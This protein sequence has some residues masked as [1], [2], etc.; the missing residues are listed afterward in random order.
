MRASTGDGARDPHPLQV[1]CADLVFRLDQPLPPGSF[2]FPALRGALG[3]ALSLCPAEIAREF[4]A[5][6]FHPPA[7]RIASWRMEPGEHCGMDPSLL[8]ARFYCFGPTAAED[9]ATI[10]AALNCPTLDLESASFRVRARFCAASE[11]CLWSLPSEPTAAPTLAPALEVIMRTPV[12]I[13]SKGTPIRT[14]SFRLRSLIDS[15][16]LRFRHLAKLGPAHLPPIPDTRAD[17]TRLRDV[18]VHLPFGHRRCRVQGLSGQIHVPLPP[19]THTH[20]LSLA[21]ALGAGRY[22]TFGIGSLRVGFT[23]H[24]PAR[25]GDKNP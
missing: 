22:T 6:R 2:P 24:P 1:A 14:N 18:E 5:R 4:L 13:G 8:S 19:P 3:W 20:W 17:L 21:E 7:P 16:R 12:A 25:S 23:S 15:I 10:T 11:T 9:I